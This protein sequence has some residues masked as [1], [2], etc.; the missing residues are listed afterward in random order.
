MCGEKLTF[1]PIKENKDRLIRYINRI[2]NKKGFPGM[3][4][5]RKLMNS[6]DEDA[7]FCNK[8]LT[9]YS[10][11]ASTLEKLIKDN[12]NNYTLYCEICDKRIPQ[13]RLIS[14]STTCSSK[15]N[16][17]IRSK[18]ISDKGKE[19]LQ[20]IQIKRNLI[21]EEY[22]KNNNI[23]E[24]IDT[25]MT[26]IKKNR[27]AIESYLNSILDK[28]G[29]VNIC[30]HLKKIENNDKLAILTDCILQEY[31]I[32]LGEL[33][34]IINKNFVGITFFCKTC[35]KRLKNCLLSH[36]ST[37]CA[38]KDPETLEKTKNTVFERF[39]VTYVAQSEEIKDKVKKTIKERYG[40]K[41]SK[42][43]QKILNKRKETNLKKYGVTCSL[44]NPDVHKKTKETMLKKFGTEYASQSDI[45]KQKV[46]N[47]CIK[48]YG[49]EYSLQTEK[50]KKSR[51]TKGKITRR[52]K[53][54]KDKFEELLKIFSNKNLTLLTP[55]EEYLTAE[56]LKVK[57]NIC[58]TEFDFNYGNE[59]LWCPKC[60]N[61]HSGGEDQVYYFIRS[62]LD[63][64]TEVLRNKRIILDNKM[65]LD[66]FIPSKKVAIEFDG[67]YW[68]S[69]NLA[70]MDPKYHLKKTELCKEKG[71]TLVH[72]FENEWISKRDIVESILCN[73]LGVY[74]EKIFARKCEVKKLDISDYKKFIEKN[75]IQGYAAADQR[76]G[77]LYNGEI[78]ACVGIGNSRFK[79]EETELIRFCTKLNT[80]VIGALSKLLK[81][82]KF[83]CLFSYLDRRYFT[84]EGYEKCG[85]KF[86]SKTRPGY[87]YINGTNVLTRYQC[88]KHKLH[89]LLG[90]D[91]DSKLS[92]SENMAKLRYH[93]VFDCGMLKFQ[94][95]RY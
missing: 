46:K 43:F 11:T 37:K 28:K 21:F 1:N 80:V 7:I 70:K 66:I 31:D 48:R 12:F 5:H 25:N 9:M 51:E 2:R 61:I 62:I 50:V 68:H 3:D 79:K 92:E 83:N 76:I 56:N 88:Q 35:G 86:I 63:K 69:S 84:G 8:F 17:N 67:I 41:N 13:K 26:S 72:V 34:I 19:Y 10:I 20:N 22:K 4:T 74:K 59:Y 6:N 64:E 18:K 58:N 36:C 81:H 93:Q 85:F 82:A 47:T 38:S 14:H 52:I 54:R 75:H 89:K 90:D 45:I 73:K 77:L 42:E 49:V 24:E 94:L 29:K 23:S 55:Y 44:C 32:T 15:C 16:K 65:E 87:L 60:H 57:C 27:F 30:T 91:F 71:I 78:V 33:H 53:H 95:N 40:N 39:G